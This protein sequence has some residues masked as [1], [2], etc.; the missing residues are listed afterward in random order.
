MGV[1]ESVFISA[2]NDGF[3][4]SGLL[5]FSLAFNDLLLAEFNT[6]VSGVPLSEGSGVDLDDSTLDQSVGS[7]EFV[8]GGVIDDHDD[9]GLSGDL[10]RSPGEVT[11]IKSEGLEFVV[12]SSNSVSSDGLFADLGEGGRT[13]RFVLLL[14]LVDGHTTTGKSSLVSE[15]TISTSNKSSCELNGDAG[16]AIQFSMGA[17]IILVL[18]YKR[19]REKP[20]RHWKIWL[21]DVSKQMMS[22]FAAHVCNVGLATLL[23]QATD[24]SNAD[25]CGWYFITILF[26]TTLG[27]VICYLLL[28][29]VNKLFV[30][31]NLER[32][33]SGNYYRVNAG[34]TFQKKSVE[35]DYCVWFVQLLIWNFIV[36]LSKLALFGIQYVL[37]DFLV[38]WTASLFSGLSDQPIVKLVIVMMIVPT[39]M[40]SFQFW[41][42]DSFLKKTLNKD[43]A[44]YIKELFFESDNDNESDVELD[45]FGYKGPK[46]SPH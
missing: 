25:V 43:E 32:F 9:L 16:I 35:I 33:A 19:F 22:A 36:V 7:D 26:D 37:Q 12:S 3:N 24:D 5:D 42:Q 1:D 44:P 46:G 4:V 21:L 10:F 29:G 39:I 34:N 8:V 13:T 17:L 11:S 15:S 28:S 45:E 38:D 20:R 14:L 23:T 2:S 6:V 40:N 31:G 18:T 41:I 30:K 27:V